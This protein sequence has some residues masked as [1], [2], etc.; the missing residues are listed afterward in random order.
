MSD[1]SLCRGMDANGQQCICMRVDETYVDDNKRT[2]CRSCDHIASAHPQAPPSV[3]A[4]VR[5]FRDAGKI[6]GPSSSSSV[7]ALNSSSVKAS[8]QDAEA[9]TST[10]L[11]TKKRKSDAVAALPVKKSKPSKGKAKE[12]SEP[13]GDLVKYGKAVLLP[14]GILDGELRR[15]KIP[16][17]AA[18]QDLRKAGMVVLSSLT[19]PLAINTAWDHHEVDSEVHR[20]FGDPM[21]WLENHRSDDNRRGSLWRGAIAHKGNLTLGGD[22][23]PTG[24]ELIDYFKLPGRPIADRI[25]YFAC[26]TRIPERRWDWVQSDSDDLG[27]E[28]DTVPSEGIVRTPPKPRPMFKGKGKAIVKVKIEAESDTEEPD[29]RKAAKAR[30]RLATGALKKSEPLFIPGSDDMEVEVGLSRSDRGDIVIVSDDDN[31]F[32]EVPP[33]PW[34]TTPEVI[35]SPSPSFAALSPNQDPPSFYDDFSF[36]SPPPQEPDAASNVTSTPAATGPTA[37]SSGSATGSSTSSSLF[38]STFSP[39][40]PTPTPPTITAPAPVISVPAP[41]STPAI[42]L[43]PATSTSRR[44]QRMGKGRVAQ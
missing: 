4:L 20:L 2:L 23:E 32:P 21:T 42:S 5:G 30:T 27:S 35:K 26:K 19:N 15:S 22:V 11:R 16:T 34:K 37:G 41:E 7:K 6:A 33:V 43:P 1:S 36:F 44:F 38:S 17:A 40:I 13:E 31:D 14:Y 25:L 39:W 24:V 9:E 12:K 28:I 29:M 8:L 3:T 18:L 10:G